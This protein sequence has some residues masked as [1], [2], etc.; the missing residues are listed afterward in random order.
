MATASTKQNKKRTHK[1]VTLQYHS[2]C[3]REV[4]VAGTFNDWD[5]ARDRLT[6]VASN[7]SF[8]A[9]LAL[10]KG[11]HEYKFVVDSV[12]CTDPLNSESA[13]NDQGSTNSVLVVD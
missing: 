9:T 11:R 4:F 8:R 7:G 3:A 13:P 5:P 10:P 12:W 6:R 2:G 1:S